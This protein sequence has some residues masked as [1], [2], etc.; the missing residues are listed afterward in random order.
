[1]RHG[2]RAEILEFVQVINCS[3]GA[4]LARKPSE[5][6]VPG[7]KSEPRCFRDVVLVD[8][9][10]VVLTD[11]YRVFVIMI[12]D[13]AS[14]LAVTFPPE[15]HDERHGGRD[16]RGHR[17]SVAFLG[18]LSEGPTWGPSPGTHRQGDGAVLPSARVGARHHAC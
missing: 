2:V 4:E 17:A 15:R 16:L 6:V 14:R 5:P 1:M 18:W 11:G 3:V 13:Q 10:F 7:G 12:C 8:E 9:F